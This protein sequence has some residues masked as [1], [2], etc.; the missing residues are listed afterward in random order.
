[1][2]K[3][4]PIIAGIACAFFGLGIIINPRFYSWQDYR[5]FDF[6]GIKW[7]F[8]ISLMAIG[9]L[10]IWSALRKS[11]KASE[12]IFLICPK[13]EKPFRKRGIPQL[14][15]PECNVDL[16]ASKGFYTRH[17]ELGERNDRKVDE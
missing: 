17:P 5:Y 11:G 10:F 6:T 7:P 9:L 3:A 16:E 4:L 8:G 13:C 14:R 1:M 12:E 15:C 2:N